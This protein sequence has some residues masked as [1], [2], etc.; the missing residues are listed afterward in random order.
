ML[1]K[2]EY[3]LYFSFAQRGTGLIPVW[4]C[5]AALLNTPQTVFM[6]CMNGHYC[7][8]DSNSMGLWFS[9]HKFKTFHICIGKYPSDEY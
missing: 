2:P 5:A 8:M 7:F 4:D 1:N 3:V 9:L 6:F